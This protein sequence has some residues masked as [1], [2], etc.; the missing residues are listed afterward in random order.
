MI[1]NGR[2]ELDR[3]L[4]LRPYPVHRYFFDFGNKVLADSEEVLDV[5]HVV[6]W[7]DA[8][9][10]DGFLARD[11]SNYKLTQQNSSLT[12]IA[13]NTY[14]INRVHRVGPYTFTRPIYRPAYDG[15]QIIYRTRA[16]VVTVASATVDT[17][18]G[19]ATISGHAGGDTYTCESEFDVALTFA[20]D[21]EFSRIA[22]DGTMDQRFQ[23]FGSI[24]LVEVLPET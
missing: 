3:Q 1:Y 22:I 21:D 4:H 11:W 6:L 24:E 9:P 14:Q 15:T 20:N 5:M 10:Y 7:G 19:I 16:S 13:G 8:G 17:A 18:T 12:L 2:G 23:T